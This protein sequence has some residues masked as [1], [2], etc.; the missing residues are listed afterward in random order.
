[1]DT[2]VTKGSIYAFDGTI[3]IQ[4]YFLICFQSFV[5]FVN[6]CLIQTCSSVH[7]QIVGLLTLTPAMFVFQSSKTLFNGDSLAAN[8]AHTILLLVPVLHSLI[9]SIVKI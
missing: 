4:I 1:M 9:I 6:E 7:Q 5:V 8:V 2:N 3:V